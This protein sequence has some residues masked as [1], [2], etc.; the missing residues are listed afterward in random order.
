[1]VLT[2]TS[3]PVAM[4]SGA[5][6]ER[7]QFDALGTQCEIQFGGVDR[8]QAETFKRAAL[9]WVQSFEAKYSRFRPD[10]LISRINNAAGHGWTAIDAEAEQIFALADQIFIL[11][12]GIIDPTALPLLQL[13]NYQAK[14]PTVP[15]AE[16]VHSTLAKIGWTKVQ[17]EPGRI[18]LPEPG[19]GLDLGGFG[20]EYAVD[21]VAALATAHGITNVLVDFGHD[22]RVEGAPPTAPA[23]SIG[24]EN[25]NRPGVI[26]SR[27]VLNSGGVATSGDYVRFFQANGR[28]YG[29]IIDPRTGYPVAHECNAVT[30]LAASCLEAGLLSTTAFVLGEADGLQLLE[31]SFGSEGSIACDGH[32][33][34]TRG[35]YRYVI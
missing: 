19:M 7:M 5:K 34:Q 21:Q 20:K 3:S 32:E 15:T 8:T 2:D 9:G 23:W 16:A 29:H 31:E 4:Q 30:V 24:V 33:L 27:L 12:H 17:R 25:P 28:R 26:R 22:V 6:L 18:V 11:T 13:W 35:F 10:S 1:M 14:Q